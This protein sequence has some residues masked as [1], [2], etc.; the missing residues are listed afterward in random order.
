MREP[1]SIAATL[2]ESSG[3]AEGARRIAHHGHQDGSGFAGHEGLEEADLAGQRGLCDA[4][5]ARCLRQGTVLG[6][7]H[8][9]TKSADFHS[10]Q[11]IP[12]CYGASTNIVLAV[13]PVSD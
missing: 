6:N 5:N 12:S 8:K 4:Q 11:P 10:P 1:S 9:I 2:E 13:Y 3:Y 7:A